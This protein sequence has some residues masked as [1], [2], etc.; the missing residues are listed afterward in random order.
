M[1]KGGKGKGK[2]APVLLIEHYAMKRIGGMEV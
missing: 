2:V 1:Y